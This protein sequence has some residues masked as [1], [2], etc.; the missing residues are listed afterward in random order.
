M[1][2]CK[3]NS[4]MTVA[5]SQEVW[6][7]GTVPL[8]PS[9]KDEVDHSTFSSTS[10]LDLRKLQDHTFEEPNLHRFATAPPHIPALSD[11]QLPNDPSGGEVTPPSLEE[12]RGPC[13]SCKTDMSD[14]SRREE[15][16]LSAQEQP[17]P[18]PPHEES[19]IESLSEAAVQV[20][21]QVHINDT[22]QEDIGLRELV[23]AWQLK[24][25]D[26]RSLDIF[27]R[28]ESAQQSQIA[29]LSGKCA[30]LLTVATP[31]RINGETEK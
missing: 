14:F 2:R 29:E 19:V 20:D 28:M 17:D 5:K 9:S 11:D 30:E 21:A 25:G 12:S 1:R 15:T 18:I 22:Q 23:A 24:E 3:D 27:H 7:Q 26:F 13:W 8:P 6:P 10:T 4:H 31:E 16:L